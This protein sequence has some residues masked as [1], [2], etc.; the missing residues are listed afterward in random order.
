MLL[1]ET[2][3]TVGGVWLALSAIGFI[4]GAA[5]V[6]MRQDAGESALE[7]IR[8]LLA[9]GRQASPGVSPARKRQLEHLDTAMKRPKPSADLV[10]AA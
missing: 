2:F 8:E 1:L 4:L 9:D 10:K 5:F 3:E 6:K 7:S